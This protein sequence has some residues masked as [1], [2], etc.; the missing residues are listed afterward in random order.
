MAFMTP[1]A[2]A[3]FLLSV[4]LSWEDPTEAAV[5]RIGHKATAKMHAPKAYD[6]QKQQ[7]TDSMELLSNG[8]DAMEI[9]PNEFVLMDMLDHANETMLN[10]ANKTNIPRA[11]VVPFPRISNALIGTVVYVCF[12]ML[13]AYLY[14]QARTKYP[15]EFQPNPE[16]GVLPRSSSFSF[17]LCSC[18]S[19]PKICVIGFCCPC[20]RWADTLDRQGVLQYWLAFLAMFSL[21]LLNIYTN[22]ISLIPVAILGVIYRQQLREHFEIENKTVSSVAYDCIVWLCCQP[23][24][25]IQEAREETVQ[26]GTPSV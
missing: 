22:G 23:C 25:I 19:D 8:M 14:F 11:V 13:F 17:D 6:D 3:F 20:M 12:A 7:K 2:E 5:V 18:L 26:R 10:H 24:A 4:V 9:F 1:R 15:K 21:T 16:P